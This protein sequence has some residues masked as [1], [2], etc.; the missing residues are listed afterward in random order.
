MPI[1]DLDH[2]VVADSYDVSILNLYPYEFFE[3]LKL[4]E[5]RSFA[6]FPS[7]VQIEPR[8][9]P[10]F[11]SR[12]WLE[13]L[14]SKRR[15]SEPP[16]RA[17]LEWPHIR[18]AADLFSS[19]RFV[20]ISDAPLEYASASQAEHVSLTLQIADPMRSG[21]V[22]VKDVNGAEVARFLPQNIVGGFGGWRRNLSVEL[23]HLR[24]AQFP[25]Q[26]GVGDS[27]SVK[28]A[29]LVE[30]DCQNGIQS[31]PPIGARAGRLPGG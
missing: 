11:F 5:L 30:H 17:R 12:Y 3:F 2:H 22:L 8:V 15:R 19:D 4:A 18:R 21:D 6:S 25:V 24:R 20:E 31:G 10:D 1:E 28:V 13:V 7:G 16:R 9:F 27:G 14:L 26:I 23:P 29:A